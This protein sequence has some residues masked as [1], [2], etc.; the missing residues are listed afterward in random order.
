MGAKSSQSKSGGKKCGRNKIKC[1]R[2]RAQNRREKNRARKFAKHLR[3]HPNDAMAH[4]LKK[5]LR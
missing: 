2:Y 5:E 3:L 4:E 1:D